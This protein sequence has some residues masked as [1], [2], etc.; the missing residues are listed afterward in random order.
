MKLCSRVGLS[1][2]LC[3]LLLGGAA[4]FDGVGSQRRNPNQPCAIEE[5]RPH[6]AGRLSWKAWLLPPLPPSSPLCCIL[7]E[8]RGRRHPALRAAQDLGSLTLVLPSTLV[9]HQVSDEGGGIPR[10]GLP[11]IWSYL[12]S[13]AKVP[14]I[15]ALDDS[16]V[17]AGEVSGCSLPPKPLP[18][19]LGT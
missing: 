14:I 2:F 19:T 9:L 10:S 1:C 16:Q 3:L 7:G 13:T 18:C 5:R 6:H 8:R 17:E 4:G 12:F 15:E 11:K